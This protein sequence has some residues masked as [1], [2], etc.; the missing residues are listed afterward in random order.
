MSM[1]IGRLFLAIASCLLL[2]QCG[3]I[4]TALRLAPY[5]MMFAEEENGQGQGKPGQMQNRAQEIGK[6]GHFAPQQRWMPGAADSKMA[7][8]S[9]PKRAP[10]TVR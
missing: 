4:G 9:V 2:T 3:L 1:F 8:V 6:K 7:S 10:S 5:L